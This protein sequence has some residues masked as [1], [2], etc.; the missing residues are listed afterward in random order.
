MTK[1]KIY[2][3]LTFLSIVVL[4]CTQQDIDNETTQQETQIESYIKN[5]GAKNVVVNSGVWRAVMDQG[6]EGVEK[7]VSKGDSIEYNY[8]GYIFAAGKGYLYDTNVLDLAKTLG[9]NQDYSY[10]TPRKGVVGNGELI[11]GLDIGLIGAKEGERCYV[12]FSARHGFGNVQTGM[13]PKMSPLLI[14][15]WVRDVKKN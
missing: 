3:L 12:I 15:V 1:Y 5:L 6:K 4:S 7:Q 10:F 13:I 11:S 2:L 8:A 14:E 9:T